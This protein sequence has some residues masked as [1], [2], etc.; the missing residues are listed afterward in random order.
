M[1]NQNLKWS[2][3]TASLSNEAA[4][5]DPKFKFRLGK[6]MYQARPEVGILYHTH[7]D[8][9]K[10]W[11]QFKKEAHSRKI[12]IFAHQIGR[13]AAE[14]RQIYKDGF[15]KAKEWKSPHNYS[16]AIDIVIYGRY[17][18]KMNKQQWKYLGWLGKEAARKAGVEIKWGA[19]PDFGFYDP[20][21]WQ[22]PNWKQ[23][24]AIID[25]P[26]LPKGKGYPEDEIF[27]NAVEAIQREVFI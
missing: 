3:V 9:I 20:A 16:M 2:D 22:I 11:K 8:I 1:Q 13:S 27:W 12:P 23:Y 17:W 21:H 14:Q 18:D 15:S 5:T 24:K 7:P 19:D 10:F 25:N 6:E 26:V 4:F